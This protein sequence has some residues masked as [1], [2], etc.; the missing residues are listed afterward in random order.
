MEQSVFH[1]AQFNVARIRKQI[2]SWPGSL[3]IL[4]GSMSLPTRLQVSSGDFKTP[5]GDA[6][7]IR[8]YPE[9]DSTLITLSMWESIEALFGF[10]YGRGP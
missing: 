5:E 4:R 2:Q 8:A 3:R 1:I 10:S 7:S 6:T 9:D